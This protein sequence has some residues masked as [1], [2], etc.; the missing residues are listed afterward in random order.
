MFHFF[1]LFFFFCNSGFV[2][3][4]WGKKIIRPYVIK[5]RKMQN[6]KLLD[7]FLYSIW[8]CLFIVQEFFGNPYGCSFTLSKL[9]IQSFLAFY[10]GHFYFRGDYALVKM[11]SKQL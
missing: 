3:I 6:T 4:F 10:H 8:N 2:L 1:Y 11:T 7:L 5:A 9:E